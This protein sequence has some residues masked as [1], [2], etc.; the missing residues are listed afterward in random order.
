ML[1]AQ[2]AASRLARTLLA[3]QA[4]RGI[5]TQTLPDLPYDYG[6]LAPVII[7][8]VGGWVWGQWV[9]LA[10]ADQGGLAA[11]AARNPARLSWY[12]GA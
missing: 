8:E 5:A 1:R 2:G 12:R 4:S 11:L 9:S 6:A 10:L 7:P 3:G